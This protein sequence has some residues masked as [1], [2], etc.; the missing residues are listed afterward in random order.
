MR[1][2][3]ITAVVFMFALCS[4]SLAQ[5]ITSAY[6]SLGEKA[7]KT[8]EANPDEGGSYLGECPGLGG[9]KVQLIEGDLRQTLNLI[10]PAKKKFELNFWSAFGSFSAIG[11]KLE[12]RM[13]GKNPIAIIARY[14]VSDPEDSAKTT[15][16]LIISKVSKAGACITDVIAPSKNQNAEARK[17]ADAAGQK[18][19][20]SFN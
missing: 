20:K 18:A 5:K 2:K 3:I 8:L 15:S 16:H 17:A 9:F 12:W 7:C 19:C 1:I 11:E 14:N 13:K 10:S 6:T 4:S